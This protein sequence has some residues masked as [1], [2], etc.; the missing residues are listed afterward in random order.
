MLA[1]LLLHLPTLGRDGATDED[2]DDDGDELSDHH[3]EE[4][5]RAAVPRGV[6]VRVWIGGWG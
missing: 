4:E 3:V 1:D 2:S 5:H 6:R